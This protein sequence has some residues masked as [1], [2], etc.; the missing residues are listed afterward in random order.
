[1]TQI[2]SQNKQSSSVLKSVSGLRET[3]LRLTVY[4]TFKKHNVDQM[5]QTINSFVPKTISINSTLFIA[6]SFSLILEEL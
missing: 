4:K 1:M 3:F 5:N 2:Q 6:F